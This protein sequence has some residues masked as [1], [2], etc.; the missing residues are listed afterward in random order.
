[1]FD[2]YQLFN[3]TIDIHYTLTFFGEPELLQ[4]K[5]YGVFFRSLS[6]VPYC[7]GTSKGAMGLR[8]SMFDWLG[9]HL[10]F[11]LC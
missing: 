6:G 10:E 7:S 9:S 5:L 11:S 4:H 2:Y 8:V 1:M 3:Q